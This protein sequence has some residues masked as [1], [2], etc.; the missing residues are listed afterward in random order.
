MDGHKLHNAEHV[1]I[2]SS[3]VHVLSVLDFIKLTGKIACTFVLRPQLF[4]QH[5]F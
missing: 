5:V 2:M 3:I 1:I 4:V